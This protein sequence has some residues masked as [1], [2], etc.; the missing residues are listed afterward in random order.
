MSD[1]L[2]PV[3]GGQYGFGTH[4]VGARDGMDALR[5]GA[6]TPEAE[7]PDGY[8]GTIQS[9]REDRVLDSLKAR[10]GDRQYQRGVH[11]G[12]KRDPRSYVWPAEFNDQSGLAAQAAGRR[13]APL[14]SATEQLLYLDTLPQGAQHLVEQPRPTP[15]PSTRRAQLGPLSPSWR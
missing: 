4:V 14:Q 6:R 15:V 9:R 13:Q 1:W 12:E 10:L 3:S 11:V 2:N 8:L 5:M 7:Y